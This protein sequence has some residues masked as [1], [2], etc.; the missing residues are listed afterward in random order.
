MTHKIIALRG[1]ANVGKSQTIKNV[2]ESLVSKFPDAKI[3]HLSIGVDIRVVITVNG[4]KVGIESQGDPSSRLF[5]SIKLFVEIKCNVIICAT[6]T[7]G[8]TVDLVESQ[9]PEYSILWHEQKVVSSGKESQIKS[10]LA[11]AITILDEALAVIN[12]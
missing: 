9:K 5:S 7:R 1:I 12:A 11:M 6:R 4:V 10:N 8:G 3:E 2:Y